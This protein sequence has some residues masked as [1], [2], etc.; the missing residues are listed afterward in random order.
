MQTEKCASESVF[1]MRVEKA[2]KI[3]GISTL[4]ELAK[5]VNISE[6]TIQGW[7]KEGSKPQRRTLKTL[8]EVLEVDSSWLLGEGDAVPRFRP[9]GTSEKAQV[10]PTPEAAARYNAEAAIR[11]VGKLPERDRALGWLGTMLMML[12]S[13]V[14]DGGSPTMEA[15]AAKILAKIFR[16]ARG[17]SVDPGK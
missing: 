12:G 11:A 2:M 8:S 6:A 9:H 16:S 14:D 15:E 10:L 7:K 4:K 5:K 17:E 1:F 13:G 3:K